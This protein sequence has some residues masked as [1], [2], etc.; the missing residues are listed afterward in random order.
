MR[1][2]LE[3]LAVICERRWRPNDEQQAEQITR[4]GKTAAALG[5]DRRRILYWHHNGLTERAADRAAALLNLH[6]AEVWPEWFDVLEVA[7]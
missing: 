2:P 6:P 4:T 7:A 1:Y 5:V 3:P